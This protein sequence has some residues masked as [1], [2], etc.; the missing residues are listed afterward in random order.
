MADR[1]PLL[2]SDPLFIQ[3]DLGYSPEVL[4]DMQAA[5]VTFDPSL[6]P[7]LP[8]EEPDMIDFAKDRLIDVGQGFADI[9]GFVANYFVQPD[10]QGQPSFISPQEFGQDVKNVGMAMGQAIADD[11]VGFALDITPGISNVRA[12][13]E[14]NRL[15]QQADEQE[16]QGDEVGAAKTRSMASLTMTDMLNP[17]PTGLAVKGIFAGPMAQKAPQK[18]S[19]KRL[20][21]LEEVSDDTLA[22]EVFED[23]NAFIG[24]NGKRQFEID[25]SNAS[26]DMDRI[27]NMY[28]FHRPEQEPRV[29]PEILNF[30][31]LYENYPQLKD[32]KVEL[33]LG[34][35]SQAIYYPRIKTMK[36]NLNQIEPDNQ[37]MTS[38]VLHETQ[39][40]VQDIEG[41]L[42][43]GSYPSDKLSFSQ[44]QK[45][46]IEVDARNVQ[47]RFEF[48]QKKTELPQFTQGVNVDE[49]T[50]VPALRKM[51]FDITKPGHFDQIEMD[52]LFKE[53]KIVEK[54]LAELEAAEQAG[55]ITPSQAAF[56][57]ADLNAEIDRLYGDFGN[58]SPK[59]KRPPIQYDLPF[60]AQNRPRTTD[61]VPRNPIDQSR[62]APY[63]NP[64]DTRDRQRRR[65]KRGY[66]E[67]GIVSL[68]NGGAV[69]H[70]VVTL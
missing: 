61:P 58:P 64:A 50:D 53:I 21:T 12:G 40:A 37:T 26:V 41:D 65:K 66:A 48:P 63:E 39:H 1:I 14:A 19:D 5:D 7:P 33:D 67:G 3:D 45:L 70:G 2:P 52:L 38:T 20:D 47:K 42:L 35:D 51:G 6:Y 43:Q 62:V 23:T 60:D 54:K 69:E 55:T 32:V 24:L 16:A 25:T 57:K 36:F 9:P 56:Y 13:M 49:L 68:A 11:P 22:Q 44:Y 10:E 4:S 30:P 46:P 18:L 15:Y 27:Q 34:M 17:V 59:S 31:E 29:L 8:P 28:R